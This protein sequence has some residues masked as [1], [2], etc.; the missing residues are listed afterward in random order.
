MWSL[1]GG[2]WRVRPDHETP[3]EAPAAALDRPV[4][5]GGGGTEEEEYTFIPDEEVRDCSVWR[6]RDEDASESNS[7]PEAWERRGRRE[8]RRESR[9]RP[10]EP[11]A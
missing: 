10:S 9:R 11:R 8:E 3:P 5:W 2:G 4:E 6:R 1:R 7:E